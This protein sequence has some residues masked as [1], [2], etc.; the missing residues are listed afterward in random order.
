[1]LYFEKEENE[2]TV[3][4]TGLLATVKLKLLTSSSVAQQL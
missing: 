4:K 2:S 1:M 3:I